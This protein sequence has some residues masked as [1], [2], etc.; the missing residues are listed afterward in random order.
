M[1]GIAGF[2]LRDPEKASKE[3]VEV[4]IDAML[5][6]IDSRGGDACGLLAVGDKEIW[7]EKQPERS[8]FFSRDRAEVPFHPKYVL[9]HTRFATLGSPINEENNHPVEY[10]GVYV[11]HNGHINNHEDMFKKCKVDRQAEVDTAIIPVLM[12]KYVYKEKG[13]VSNAVKKLDGSFAFAACHPEKFKDQIVLVKGPY[14]PLV[15]YKGENMFLWASTRAGIDAIEK[16]VDVKLEHNRFEHLIEGECVWVKSNGELTRFR[17]EPKKEFK[18][19]ETRPAT[20]FGQANRGVYVGTNTKCKCGHFKYQHPGIHDV[21]N[22][23]SCRCMGFDLEVPISQTSS[24][25]TKTQKEQ[26]E[27]AAPLALVEGNTGKSGTNTPGEQKPQSNLKMCV[28]CEDF[29]SESI[30]TEKERIRLCEA[31]APKISCYDDLRDIKDD[32]YKY[33]S[34]TDGHN[35][36]GGESSM[37]RFLHWN[38]CLTVSRLCAKDKDIV[39]EPHPQYVNAVLFDVDADEI[40]VKYPTMYADLQVFESKYWDAMEYLM[41]KVDAA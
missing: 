32:V 13:K 30:L 39:G 40:E 7:L 11:T 12:H 15:I 14:S 6:S 16:V 21:C 4:M 41:K 9:L 38:A 23:V 37:E 10:D 2:Y 28:F 3:A 22:V 26:E 29:F 34:W 18:K 25:Q 35:K 1:C 19:V 24:S 8:K 17:Y 20:G 27:D 33:L 31:C 36:Y 5:D